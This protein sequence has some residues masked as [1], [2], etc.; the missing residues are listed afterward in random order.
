MTFYFNY[1]IR[2]V[3]KKILYLSL[4]LF[5]FAANAQECTWEDHLTSLW[6]SDEYD[7]ILPVNTWHNRLAY[8]H[9]KIKEFNERPWGAGIGKRYYDED[10]DLHS[11]VAMVFMDSHDDPEPLVGYQFQKK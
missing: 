1:D 10:K 4:L 11:M 5:C 9:K 2:F 8:T 7:F 3:M 6:H